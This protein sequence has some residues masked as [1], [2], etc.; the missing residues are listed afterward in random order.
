MANQL[1]KT[2]T[3][4]DKVSVK[5]VLSEDGTTISYM[6]DKLEEEITIAECLKAFLGKPVDFSI[7]VKSE[8]ELPEEE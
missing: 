2:R 7:S 4:T 3:I 8:D 1:K 6:N 5:G